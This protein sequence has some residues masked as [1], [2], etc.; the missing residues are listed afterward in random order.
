MYKHTITWACR[1]SNIAT[2]SYIWRVINVV[3]I[4][5]MLSFCLENHL[6]TGSLQ[7]AGRNSYKVA[8]IQNIR[9]GHY[10]VYCLRVVGVWVFSCWWMGNGKKKNKKKKTKGKTRENGR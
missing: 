8:Y 9:L 5:Y 2:L 10:L 3:N 4:L 7:I 6:A 1:P